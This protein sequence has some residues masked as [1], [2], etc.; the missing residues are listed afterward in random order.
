MLFR[1]SYLWH[2]PACP[3]FNT[4]VCI[5]YKFFNIY[6]ISRFLSYFGFM[7]WSE[8]WML[9]YLTHSVHINGNWQSSKYPFYLKLNS[10]RLWVSDMQCYCLYLWSTMTIPIMNCSDFFEFDVAYETQWWWY[11]EDYASFINVLLFG[12]FIIDSFR[13]QFHSC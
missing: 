8:I 4:N 10:K 13:N 9:N 3:P 2:M 5:L 12:S 1:N 7:N 11:D 6:H